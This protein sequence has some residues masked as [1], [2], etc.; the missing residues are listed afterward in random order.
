MNHSSIFLDQNASLSESMMSTGRQHISDLHNNLYEMLEIGSD[1]FSA[2]WDL[3]DGDE[4]DF[5]TI[6]HI[7]DSF[8]ATLKSKRFIELVQQIDQYTKEHTPVLK[9]ATGV[10][11][12][13]MSAKEARRFKEQLQKMIEM[14]EQLVK[15]LKV[16]E[17]VLENRHDKNLPI[18]D[19]SSDLINL[20]GGFEDILKILDL[21]K[22]NIDAIQKKVTPELRNKIEAAINHD[23][24]AIKELEETL[25]TERKIILQLQKEN[26]QLK[27]KQGLS[28]QGK[29]TFDSTHY[30]SSN[31]GSIMDLS[32]NI[33]PHDLIRSPQNSYISEEGNST[34]ARDS[35][36]PNRR[37]VEPPKNILVEDFQE[38]E[39]NDRKTNLPLIPENET[40]DELEEGRAA[41]IT[42]KHL[43]QTI[44]SIHTKLINIHGT[45]DKVGA[46]IEEGKEKGQS[47]LK[48]C[49]ELK[50]RLSAFRDKLRKN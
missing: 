11:N 44:A 12:V 30:R 38:E 13:G 18:K 21:K 2:F 4:K 49:F 17:I 47:V 25:C 42:L 50:E 16:M 10:K 39:D 5:L 40:E 8:S 24:E 27:E 15:F 23:K 37:S 19:I 34:P 45:I 22:E 46:G 1:G 29:C 9:L 41:Q 43:E 6:D 7:E 36:T 26:R 35:F 31:E 28:K 48:S 32:E 3:I 14:K 33:L 20:G